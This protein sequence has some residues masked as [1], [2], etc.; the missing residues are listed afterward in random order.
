[1]PQDL[2]VSSPVGSKFNI[3][4]KMQI[5]F[6]KSVQGEDTGSNELLVFIPSQGYIHRAH[7]HIFFTLNY[8]SSIRSNKF[9]PLY[10]DRKLLPFMGIWGF[11][12]LRYSEFDI[13]HGKPIFV[14]FM[15][16]I[17]TQNLEFNEYL[18][19]YTDHMLY[20]GFRCGVIY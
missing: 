5:I 1:M 11:Y 16:H 18:L 14:D 12:S 10:I 3:G 9:F 6:N 2:W 13:I 4:C 15:G 19:T 17:K 20:I 8:S 7:V